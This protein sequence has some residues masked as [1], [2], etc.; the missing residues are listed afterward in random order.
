MIMVTIPIFNDNDYDD[1][2][3]NGN[4][5]DY[6][7]NRIYNKILDR[8]WFSALICHVIGAWSRGCPITGAL[9]EIFVIW[10]L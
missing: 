7:D 1:D 4:D 10:Y 6:D 2:Y 5:D 9:F 3:G 8:D